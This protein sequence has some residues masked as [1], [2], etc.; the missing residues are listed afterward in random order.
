MTETVAAIEKCKEWG[1]TYEIMDFNIDAI[2]IEKALN[3]GLVRFARDYEQRFR[4]YVA[5][6]TGPKSS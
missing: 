5:K 2:K 3:E 1:L 6:A 4:E